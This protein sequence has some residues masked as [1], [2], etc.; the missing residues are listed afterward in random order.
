MRLFAAITPPEPA[1]AH[2]YAALPAAPLRWSEPADAHI[3]LAFYG[4][5]DDLSAELL[6][7][8]L[9]D[10]ARGTPSFELRL[11]GAGT[12]GRSVLWAGVGGDLRLL[13]LLAAGAATQ[14]GHPFRPHLTLARARGA[15]DLA[16]WAE[17]L[18]AYSGP[19][20][21]VRELHLMRSRPGSA[22]RYE[23]LVTAPLLR[24][25]EEFPF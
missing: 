17:V 10:L 22:T 9:T 23:R 5:V 4:E 20:W 16:P 18:A 6:G 14:P 11:D 8:T 1:V 12:F 24:S 13:A 25:G 2:L 15:V 7:R 21:T 19:A 3:T